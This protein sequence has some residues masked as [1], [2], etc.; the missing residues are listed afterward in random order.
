MAILGDYSQSTRQN[1]PSIIRQLLTTV[2]VDCEA[3][4]FNLF[5]ASWTTRTSCTQE[6]VSI[7]VG[8]PVHSTAPS[9]PRYTPITRVRGMA[10]IRTLVRLPNT[11]ALF[12]D[13]PAPGAFLNCACQRDGTGRE[14]G[15]GFRMGNTCIPVADSC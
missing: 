4:C 8:P 2:E 6:C 1:H 11:Q 12:K 5:M 14:E 3:P 7:R 13:A 9:P 15:G 10:A